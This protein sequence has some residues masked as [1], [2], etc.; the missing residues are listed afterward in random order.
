L[1]PAAPGEVYGR[2]SS[3]VAIAALKFTIT[4]TIT[5]STS[6][7]Q[8]GPSAAGRGYPRTGTLNVD[9]AAKKTPPLPLLDKDFWDKR[10]RSA[11]RLWSGNPNPHLVSDTANLA[12]GSALDIGAG[13]GAD[14][15]WLAQRGWDVTAVDISPV[16]LERG[17]K[18]ADELAAATASRIRWLQAD[19][20]EWEPPAASFDLVLVAFMHLPSQQRLPLFQ[21]C[22]DAVAPG[23]TLLIVG[24]HPT[25]LET[26]ARRPQHPDVYFTA[27]D[28]ASAL[29]HDWEVLAQD[30][31]PSTTTDPTDKTI[32]IHD[33]VL[34]ARRRR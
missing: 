18:Q 26:T 9:D 10:Y 29:G 33:T 7:T 16:A 25:D 8:S 20:T 23:G 27:H 22:T 32:T 34:T 24:H 5:T 6:P 3:G 12:A 4:I 14:A 2:D 28:L 13:E 31:R 19:V 15:I 11:P 17:R 21:R 1:N 30:A